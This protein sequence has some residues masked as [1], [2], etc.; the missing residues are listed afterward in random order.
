MPAAP[1]ASSEA[2]RHVMQANKSKNTKP[3]LMVRRA[4][5]EAGLTG[6]RVH[7]KKAPGR[8]DICFVGRRVAIFVNGCY[9]H[10]CPYCALPRPRSHPEFW[11]AKFARNRER[12]ARDVAE[13]TAA[14]WTVVVVWECRLK[15][16]RAA[17]TM[18]EVIDVVR[19]CGT[20]RREGRVIEVGSLGARRLAGI[21]ARR[22]MRRA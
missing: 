11:E 14:G 18:A 3:E 16:A 1:A 6:Y 12:D 22:R 19:G 7:W 13:L 9:W 17:V 21:R 8:P 5:R 20:E 4:L 2:T 10:R 15:K